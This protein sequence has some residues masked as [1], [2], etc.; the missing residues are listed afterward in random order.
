[1][2]RAAHRV[3]T[4]INVVPAAGPYAVYQRRLVTQESRSV[5]RRLTGAGRRVIAVDGRTLRGSGPTRAQVHLLAAL[6]Q[7]E[8]I[9]LAQ[10]NVAQQP[11]EQ[12]SGNSRGDGASWQVT[13]DG[14]IADVVA[15]YI[16]ACTEARRIAARCAL[17][18][19]VPHHR[20]GWV[21]LCW[22]YVHM[23]EEMARHA[24]RADTL[25]EQIDAATGD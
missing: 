25:P 17:D 15:E 16:E 13:A 4:S 19:T 22:T 10:I 24:G 7:A 18:D 6:H 12:I 14:M 11:R 1:M 20:L 9:V 23:I 3:K 8:Q 5:Q 2:S 21:S